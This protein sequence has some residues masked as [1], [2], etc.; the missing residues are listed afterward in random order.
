MSSEY[1]S[2]VFTPVGRQVLGW[3]ILFVCRKILLGQNQGNSFLGHMGLLDS[4]P[5]THLELLIWESGSCK[6]WLWFHSF[7]ELPWKSL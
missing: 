7:C 6:L 3:E 2:Q 4:V 5:V 1:L